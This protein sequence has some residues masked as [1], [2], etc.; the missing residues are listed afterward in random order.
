MKFGDTLQGCR[1]DSSGRLTLDDDVWLVGHSITGPIHA[2]EKSMLMTGGVATRD[3]EANHVYAG[4]PA[5]DMTEKFGPQFEEVT[6]KDKVSRFERL[7]EEFC[8]QTGVSRN[9]FEIVKA[10]EDRADVTQFNVPLRAY[11]PIRTEEEYRFI[12]FM[13]YER[14]KWL[15]A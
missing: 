4:S 10:F 3:M 11:R 1:W 8:S 2:A 7:I 14:A 13:L 9:R 12:R 15:P 6:D 5:K